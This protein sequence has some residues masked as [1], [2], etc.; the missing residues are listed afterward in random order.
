LGIDFSKID[1]DSPLAANTTDAS[2]GMLTALAN[3]TGD[4][5]AI[6]RGAARVFGATCGMPQ[7]VGTP[8]QVANQLE[9]LWRTSDCH[10]FNITPT[11]NNRNVED[12]VD[13]VVPLLQARGIFR[14]EYESETFRDNLMN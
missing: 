10:G 14:T 2:R 5:N 8:E 11:T 6:A 13:G 9:H 4:G 3:M 12:F 1:L 7:L